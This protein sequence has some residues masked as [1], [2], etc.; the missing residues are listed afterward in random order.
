MVSFYV[1]GTLEINKSPEK[2]W[3]SRQISFPKHT[4]KENSPPT[5]TGQADGGNPLHR[6]V[7]VEQSFSSHPSSVVRIL[8]RQW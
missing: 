4:Q 2:S 7:L 5:K 6:D 8:S 3:H 1:L